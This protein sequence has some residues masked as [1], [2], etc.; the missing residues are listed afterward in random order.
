MFL[1]LE[2]RFL[3]K[4]WTYVLPIPDPVTACLRTNTHIP[5]QT[6]IM[7]CNF[8]QFYDRLTDTLGESDNLSVPRFICNMKIILCT[9]LPHKNIVRQWVDVFFTKV[10]VWMEKLIPQGGVWYHSQEASKF[11]FK[12]KQNCCQNS[13]LKGSIKSVVLLV[14]L[15]FVLKY[16]P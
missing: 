11:L 4:Q 10:K 15:G 14:V 3:L 16:F 8:L 2:T 12:K 13:S 1:I 6:F 5:T 9:F 7:K